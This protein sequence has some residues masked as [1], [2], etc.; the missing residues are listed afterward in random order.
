MT[1]S[2]TLAVFQFEYYD[3]LQRRFIRSSDYAT[4]RAIEA[5]AAL[6]LMETRM[7]VDPAHVS[8]AGYYR[9]PPPKT[10]TT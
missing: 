10:G 7:D 2:V 4:L 9:G 5:L 3:R 6:A 1:A 8:P